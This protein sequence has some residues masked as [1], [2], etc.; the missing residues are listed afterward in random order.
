[1]GWRERLVGRFGLEEGWGGL[2]GG[3]VGWAA[4]EGWRAEAVIDDVIDD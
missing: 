1:L 3:G 2:L 4:R